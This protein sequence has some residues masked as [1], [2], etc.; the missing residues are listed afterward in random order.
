MRYPNVKTPTTNNHLLT[1]S[2]TQPVPP[3]VHMWVSHF[4][5]PKNHK[6]T[7]NHLLRHFCLVA[8]L[9][10]NYRTSLTW[11]FLCFPAVTLGRNEAVD[12]HQTPNFLVRPTATVGGGGGHAEP[13]KKGVVAKLP[14][15][16]PGVHEHYLASAGC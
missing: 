8:S 1:F 16:G 3:R 2:P 7:G 14:R 11:I 9:S 10:Y 6:S 15:S 4:V 13:I 5:L 12:P